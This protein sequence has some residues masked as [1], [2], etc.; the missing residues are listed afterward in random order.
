VEDERFK[1]LVRVLWVALVGAA[2]ADA[3]RNKRDHGELF[4]FLPYDFRVPT[5]E[6]ARRQTWD[7][8]STR[9]LTP[10]TFGVGWSVNLGRIARL[11]HIV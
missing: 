5:A 4:G 11:A 8:D 3:F 1:R 9:I 10:T 7:P 6:R 2:V